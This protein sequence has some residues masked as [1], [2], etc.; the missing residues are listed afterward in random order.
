MEEKFKA[1]SVIDIFA[2]RSSKALASLLVIALEFF[3]VSSI[4]RVVTLL[5]IFIFSLWVFAVI[6]LYAK[7]ERSSAML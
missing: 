1:K 6:A 3:F 5:L 4:D 7:E 2:Y